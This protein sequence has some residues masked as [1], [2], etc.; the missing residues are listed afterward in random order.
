MKKNLI[1]VFLV[2]LSSGAYAQLNEPNYIDIGP[3]R[4]P[5]SAQTG[6][7]TGSSY[8]TNIQIVHSGWSG[9]HGI[10]FNAY[11]SDSLVSGSL[12]ALGNTKYANDLGNY[13]GGAGAIMFFG[14]GEYMDFYIPPASTG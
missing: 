4:N 10:L 1:L 9:S 13:S 14:N 11:M 2:F 6:L 3:A 5:N 7:N 12:S 8:D